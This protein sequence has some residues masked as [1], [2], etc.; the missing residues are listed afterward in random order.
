MT[1][2]VT[3]SFRILLCTSPLGIYQAAQNM[4]GSHLC[5][6]CQQ[7]PIHIK[8][9]LQRLRQKRDN[10]NGGKQYW[11][12]GCKALGVYETDQGLRFLGAKQDDDDKSSKDADT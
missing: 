3:H 1:R 10:A 6:S 8:Q 2:S 12:D 9:E 4:A 7:I 5:Q 11:S